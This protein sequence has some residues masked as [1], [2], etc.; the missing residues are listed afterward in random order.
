MDAELSKALDAHTAAVE[1]AVTKY[2]GQVK[3]A[4]K[5]SE[6]A[7]QAVRVLSEEFK[8]KMAEINAAMIDIAQ[9]STAPSSPAG[10]PL[11]AAEEFVKSDDFKDFANGGRNARA[12]IEVKNT[13]LADNTTTTWFDQ[14]P[15]IVPGARLPLTVYR[16]LPQYRT[17]T[18]SVVLM[19]E[20]SFT[21][22]AQGQTEG[23][24]KAQ[25]AMTFNKYNVAI[26][27]IAHWLKVS[28]QLLADA[29]AVVSWIENSLRWGVEA[30]VD[31]QLMSGTGTS[32]QLSGLTDSGNYTAYTPSSD[33]TL[34][35]AIN[36]AKYQL[37]ALGYIADTVYVNPADWGALERLRESSGGGQ[38]LYGPPGTIAGMN[39][40]G[41]N[42]VITP[43]IDSG[44]FL[45]GQ[46]A[47]A[48]GVWNRSG[49]VIEMGYEDN[50]FTSNL[51][52]ILAEV[53]L[54][55]GVTVPG[56]M[57]YGDFTA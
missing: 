42:V 33:D 35:D 53:R 43:R 49:A 3:E 17:G 38:Y 39:P 16:S 27:T 45:I 1:A 23:Q 15:G 19:R 44:K 47:V 9:K 37:W 56:A 28:K 31:Q 21:N 52:T 30:K 13:V 11:S 34:A 55:L 6:E 32:P 25:S 26:E 57:L 12:R 29:P 14:V 36:R 40:F 5:A 41:V 20:A 48:T 4:G 2:E 54:G 7:K 22:S 24:E 18:D 46:T 50:D 51:V 10:K 8:A